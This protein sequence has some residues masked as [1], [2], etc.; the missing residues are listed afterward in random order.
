MGILLDG[1]GCA[2]TMKS[3]MK[4]IAVMFVFLAAV[5][6][7]AAPAVPEVVP[8]LIAQPDFNDSFTLFI[9]PR[10]NPL[11]LGTLTRD[12]YPVMPTA[13]GGVYYIVQQGSVIPVPLVIPGFAVPEITGTPGVK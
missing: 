3:V 2:L 11:A 4:S 1:R 5:P 13:Y 10:R 7:Y 9:Q 8:G 12:G 6:L